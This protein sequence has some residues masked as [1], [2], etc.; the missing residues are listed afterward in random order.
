MHTLE[1]AFRDGQNAASNIKPGDTFTGA[2]GAAQD[3]G[4]A[5]DTIERTAFT[6]AYIDALPRPVITD[7]N[8][9]VLSIG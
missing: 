8:N 2:W 9:V 5:P 3:H 6:V 4:Y 1:Q 7:N